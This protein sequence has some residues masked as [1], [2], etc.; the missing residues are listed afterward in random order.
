ME[1]KLFSFNLKSAT[2]DEQAGLCASAHFY[3]CDSAT[4]QPE[5]N[6]K[7][8]AQITLTLKLSA[9]SVDQAAPLRLYPTG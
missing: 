4:L 1:R 5:L 7:E 9:G 2:H 8:L 6:H 3:S